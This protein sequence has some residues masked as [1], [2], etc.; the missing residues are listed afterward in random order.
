MNIKDLLGF[1]ENLVRKTFI[2]EFEN[3]YNMSFADGYES[4]KS[5]K[6]GELTSMVDSISEKIHA[7]IIIGIGQQYIKWKSNNIQDSVIRNSFVSANDVVPIPVRDVPNENI[8]EL[9]E[10]F[11]VHYLNTHITPSKKG[12][13]R[14]R[15]KVNIIEKGA[16]YT[17]CQIVDDIVGT[18][19]NNFVNT[20]DILPSTQVLDFACGTG[21]FYV[22]C[23]KRIA[24]ELNTDEGVAV[25]NNVN[26]ID[27]DPSAVNVTRVK[28][29]SFLSTIT[30]EQIDIISSKI[31][32][33]NGLMSEGLLNDDLHALSINDFDGRIHSGFDIIV[34]NPPYLVLKNSKKG[35]TEESARRFRNQVEY[36][37]KSGDYIYSI[38]GMLNL[39]QLSIERML[40]MLKDK[41][42]LGIIC[43]SSLFAD[44]SATKLRK[45]MLC[46]HNVR[47]IRF[48][49]E[50][51]LIFEN[52]LQA[53]VIFQLQKGSQTTSISFNDGKSSF[54]IDFGLVKQLFPDKMEIP[55]ITEPEWEI[56]KHL[57]S[58]R[59]MK[60]L[61]EI[62]NKRG[63]LD[64]TLCSPYITKNRTNHRLVRGN[65]VS[66]DGIKDINGEYVL[67][68]FLEQK[69]EDFIKN[70]FGKRRLVCQQISNGGQ[71]RRLK[72]VFC[73]KSDILGNS[74]NYLS[75]DSV[76]LKKLYIV[77][78]SSLLNWRF[79][80]TS[81]NNH[82]NNYELA[83][84]P[85]PDF[86]KIDASAKFASQEELDGYVNEAYGV[87]FSKVFE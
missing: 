6:D 46:K 34:S 70:D 81:S 23:I 29:Y 28:A 1:E 13:S 19:F 67:E 40:S 38:E 43:P 42:E 53:T 2:E 37:K 9:L 86:E 12:V 35:G 80:I 8:P 3:S 11:H 45:H 60:D 66:P 62:R 75:S 79:K 5:E 41:G 74:C 10:I 33:R 58:F 7:G 52:V 72:F 17:L 83:E 65:M 68:E 59:K 18:A 64:V 4:I 56:L 16:V 32:W 20:Q 57:S 15:S 55:F 82:I 39:Y 71:A 73:E 69:S 26:A 84:L 87:N 61:P 22:S 76:M 27:L 36:F 24:K 78:N 25:L 44:I 14:S 48:Y 50:D 30:E 85:M 49:A 54:T 51:D 47:S 31:L 77:M 63:E 21:R